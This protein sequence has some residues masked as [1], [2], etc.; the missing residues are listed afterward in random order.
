MRNIILH[1]RE[2]R[3]RLL[4]LPYINRQTTYPVDVLL[5]SPMIKL[6]TGPR[7]VGKSVFALLALKNTNFAYLNFDDN[8]LLANWNE[9]IAMQTLHDVYL[10]FQYLL[11]DEVQNLPNWDLWVTTLYRRGYNLIITGSNARM[12]SQEMAT[13]LTGRY[14]PIA[15]YP[16]SLPETLQWYDIDPINIPLESS[17]KVISIQDDYLRLGGYP[18]IIKTRALAQSYLSTLYDSILLKDVA[19]RHKIRNTEG[20]YNLA[21][22]LLANFCNLITANDIT[23]EFGLKS[24]TTTQKF[25]NYLHEPYLFFYLQRFNNKLKVMKKA[26]RKVYVVDNGFVSTTAFNISENLGR[27]L[28]N[29]VF[30]ELI[31]QGYDT[32]NTLFYYRSRNDKEV[33]FVT[34]KGVKVEKLIQVCYD[35]TS[36]KTRRREIDALIEVAGELKCQTLQIISYQHK[37]TIEEKSFTIQ[38]I[39]FMEW[40]N[41][42]ILVTPE[43]H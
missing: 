34:R 35:L 1:Q 21:G 24:V 5:Q 18:E 30:V 41:K 39:P 10:D 40:V 27:L 22:Y 37:E 12:L 23:N 13:V 25:L 4:S 14:I 3:D 42:P 29:Q 20:L 16:F 6:I 26:A 9:D 11:L 32:E 2:E 17:A 28:E 7:R 8:Q 31:R 19:K 43:I 36:E 33:D 15:M 38:V